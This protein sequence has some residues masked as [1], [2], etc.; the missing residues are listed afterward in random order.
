MG[1]VF[2]PRSSKTQRTPIVEGGCP[3]PQVAYPPAARPKPFCPLVGR[4]LPPRGRTG[5]RHFL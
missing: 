2:F 4:D 1:A 3:L 5:G